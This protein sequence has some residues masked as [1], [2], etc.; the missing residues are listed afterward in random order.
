MDR[1]RIF[2]LAILMSFS[3]WCLAETV[4]INSADAQTIAKYVKG[5]G[6]SR[7]ESIVKYRDAHGG[8]KDVTELMKIKGIGD[9]IVAMN[10]DI[11]VVGEVR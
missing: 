11:L 1:I 5:V 2:V 3:S 6:P 9:R 8:F 4:D 10:K 7:A